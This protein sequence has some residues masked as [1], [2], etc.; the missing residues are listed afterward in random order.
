DD[1]NALLAIIQH[2]KI[3][4]SEPLTQQY[5][6]E[7][8]GEFAGSLSFFRYQDGNKYECRLCKPNG[9]K[10]GKPLVSLRPTHFGENNK[11]PEP[12]YVPPF[13]SAPKSPRQGALYFDTTL[14]RLRYFDGKD[15]SNC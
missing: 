13:S 8:I 12:L 9:I 11:N 3:K 10:L 4:C 15:W 14:K 2:Y 1:P 5:S 6:A 7:E